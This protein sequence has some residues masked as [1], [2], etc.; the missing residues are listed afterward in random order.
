MF[1]VIVRPNDTDR[2]E[3]PIRFERNDVLVY[4]G[5]QMDFV[6]TTLPNILAELDARGRVQFEATDGR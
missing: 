4:F 5:D 1:R 6:G 3:L 2:H